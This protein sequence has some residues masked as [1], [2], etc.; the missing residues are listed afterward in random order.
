MN[1]EIAVRE[2]GEVEVVG[3]GEI[4]AK[5]AQTPS[6]TLESVQALTKLVELQERQDAQRRKER[7]DQALLRCQSDMPRV[8]KH[9]FI[10]P[11]GANVPYARL[12]D[13]DA[14]IRKIYQGHGFTVTYDAPMAA[15]GGKIRNVARF[16]CAGHTEAQEITA[17]PSNRATGRLQLTDAQK[18][19]QTITECRR[20]LLEMFFNIITVGADEQGA[21]PIPESEARKVQD[22]LESIGAGAG[23]ALRAAFNKT[24]GIER[25]DDLTTDQIEDA[26]KRIN[27]KRGGK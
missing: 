26:W 5:I 7:F 16:S 1:S 14:A 9:G 21:E 10:D 25:V 8:T 22:A 12:E 24:F 6:L 13:V 23:T 20:H 27:A 11:K 15:D 4:I 17:A 3:L 19:K 18:V 2:A